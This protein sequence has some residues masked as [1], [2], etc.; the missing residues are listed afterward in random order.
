MG[1]SPAVQWYPKDHL[2]SQRVSLMD[3][4]TEGAYRRLLDYCWLH[5]SIPNDFEKICMLVG[6]DCTKRIAKEIMQMFIPVEG[7]ET[8]LVSER[9]EEE[10]SK[11]NDFRRRQTENGSKGGRPRKNPRVILGF[12]NGNPNDNP[13]KALHSPFSSLLNNSKELYIGDKP[14]NPTSTNSVETKEKKE[15][16]SAQKERKIFVPP[17]IEEAVEYVR[18]KKGSEW[19]EAHIK[20]LA[21]KFWNYYDSKDWKRGGEKMS[22][23]KSAASNAID[24]W[25]VNGFDRNENVQTQPAS[26]FKPIVPRDFPM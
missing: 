19:T 9:Q 14:Q 10:R 2:S 21:N 12:E 22:R 7:D 17:T 11:Q 23:W 16:S 3:L 20:A 5:G 25:D 24:D 4:K 13:E 18:E 8:K 15:K 1:K 6:K 26:T